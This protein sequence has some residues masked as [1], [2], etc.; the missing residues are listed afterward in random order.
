MI[1]VLVDAGLSTSTMHCNRHHDMLRST[2]RLQAGE[3]GRHA[4]GRAAG[5]VSGQVHRR[6]STQVKARFAIDGVFELRAQSVLSVVSWQLEE[7]D[8]GRGTRQAGDVVASVA[9]RK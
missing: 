8:A 2:D 9:E 5:A 3:R 4:R 1:G 7:V 6:R